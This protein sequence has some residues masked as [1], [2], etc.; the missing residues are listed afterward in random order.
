[1][2]LHSLTYIFYIVIFMSL[3][4]WFDNSIFGYQHN[5]MVLCPECDKP[6][7]TVDMLVEI[8]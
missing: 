2:K 6:I 3:K 5:H 4:R 1:M 7:L 8:R